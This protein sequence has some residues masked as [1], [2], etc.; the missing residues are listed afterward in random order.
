LKE[1]KHPK[2]KN[3][4][5]KMMFVSYPDDHPA[6]CF[7]MWDPQTERTHFARDVIF[8][9]KMYFAPCIGAGEGRV[10]HL[11]NLYEHL[12][13]ENF[14]DEE[15]G[16]AEDD[17]TDE[18]S[19]VDEIDDDEVEINSETSG[20]DYKDGEGK[21]NNTNNNTSVVTKSGRT[22]V[23]VSRVGFDTLG[24]LQCPMVTLTSAEMEDY[25]MV[26][27]FPEAF[28]YGEI[29]NGWCRTWEVDSSIPRS[30]MS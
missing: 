6:D 17:G 18:P 19:V 22:S 5:I 1:G 12:N 14:D 20:D 13:D 29:C 8:L 21:I 7:T 27:R 11:S 23:L 30:Y 16:E 25:R 28:G 2:M 9:Q 26:E 10:R 3:K 4:G 15:Q 24:N